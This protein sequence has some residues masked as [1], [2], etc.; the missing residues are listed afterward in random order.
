MIMDSKNIKYEI[1]DI[2][3]AGREE[4][5]NFMQTNSTSNGGTASDPE[6]RH[7]LPP[8]VFNDDEYCGDYDQFE[9]ANEIDNLEVFLKLSPEEIPQMNKG[10]LDTSKIDANHPNGKVI[11]DEASEDKENKTEDGQNQV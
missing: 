10:T 1:V 4:D 9:L 7:P 6:P 5:K 11:E 3:E 2:S 8:Q